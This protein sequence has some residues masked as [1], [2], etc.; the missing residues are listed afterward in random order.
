MTFKSSNEDFHLNCSSKSSNDRLLTTSLLELSDIPFKSSKQFS[1]CPHWAE[2]IDLWSL[3]SLRRDIQKEN[4][5][6]RCQ[7]EFHCDLGLYLPRHEKPVSAPLTTK[8]L[9]N[10]SKTKVLTKD[11]QPERIRILLKKEKD[12]LQ[13][14][15]FNSNED[16][17]RSS[18]S[19][20]MNTN[21]S[22][23][24]EDY[25][26]ETNHQEENQRNKT[27]KLKNLLKEHLTE[28]LTRGSTYL[29]RENQQQ[30]QQNSNENSSNRKENLTK[31]VD[32]KPPL[33]F[34]VSQIDFQQQ[35]HFQSISLE[36]MA[37]QRN[38]HQDLNH[39]SSPLSSSSSSSRSASSKTSRSRSSSS[40]PSHST[41][42]STQPHLH[43][44][45]QQ[46]QTQS[47]STTMMMTFNQ[48]PSSLVRR[49]PLNSTGSIQMLNT[50]KLTSSNPIRRKPFSSPNPNQS[51]SNSNDLFVIG[52]STTQKY[53]SNGD[54]SKK[55]S[56]YF[57]PNHRRSHHQQSKCL[58]TTTTTID[59]LPPIISGKRL[60]LPAANHRYL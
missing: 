2:G 12:F 57:S 54:P 39:L 9:S 5:S 48:L 50:S 40:S 10:C 58:T 3:S 31:F 27:E 52:D 51:N 25:F 8:Y 13:S 4:D 56:T 55:T 7:Y 24:N 28:M 42:P 53:S 59:L 11:F 41:R 44:H 60:H 19:V 47:S 46:H 6:S 26:N 43:L 20:P 15:N 33:G 32:E 22:N 30:Q 35:K 17:R 34:R 14:T 45:H 49:N 16:K 18:P 21:R 23:Q 29:Q 38:S 37:Q 1:H 36:K